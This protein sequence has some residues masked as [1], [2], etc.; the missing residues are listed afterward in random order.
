MIRQIPM[1]VAAAV[2][3]LPV[4]AAAQGARNEVAIQV[5]P[6]SLAKDERRLRS[7]SYDRD[8]LGGWWIGGSL[9][10]GNVL[11]GDGD[12]GLY[13]IARL[14]Y[15]FEPLAGARWIQPQVGVEY[16]GTSNLFESVNLLGVF[17]GVYMVM[18]PELGF[19]VDVWTGQ[20]RFDD[21]GPF[22]GNVDRKRTVSNVRFGLAFRF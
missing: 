20:G 11:A 7:L 12:D 18:S 21:T 1:M 6:A 15:R 5:A 8:M 9:G 16:G 13:A 22:A 17:G 10:Y 4:V 19:T 14:R 2:A 3:L